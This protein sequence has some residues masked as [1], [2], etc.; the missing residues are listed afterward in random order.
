MTYPDGTRVS[1]TYDSLLRPTQMKRTAEGRETLWVDYKY[2]QLGRLSEKR[3]SGGYDKCTGAQ[4]REERGRPDGRVP[5]GS[6]KAVPQS[7]GTLQGGTQ[8]DFLLGYGCVS[9]GG[10]EQDHTVLPV[11]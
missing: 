11:R 9:H 1:W 4:N 5:A 8:T 10:R 3:S 7:A 2:D 6:D